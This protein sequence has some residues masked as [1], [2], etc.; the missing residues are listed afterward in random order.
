MDFDN[1][2]ES[3]KYL[4]RY[5]TVSD[6]NIFAFEHDRLYFSTPENFNDPFD[7]LIYANVDKILGDVA[8]H[9]R[10]GMDGYIEKLK[11]SNPQA[12]FLAYHFWNGPKK[13]EL[14]ESQFTAICE[15]VDYI[16]KTLRENVKIICFSEVYDSML[17]WSH[18]ANNHKGFLLMYDIEELKHAKRFT[19]DEIE[20]DKHIRVEKVKYVTE[21][22][23]LSE[24]VEDFVRCNMMPTMGD[25]DHGDGK[26]PQY[27]LKEFVI[28]KAKDWEYEQE[29]R[30]IPRIIDLE[31]PS[32]L[33]YIECT[34]KAVILGA[35][36]SQENGLK[37][38]KIAREKN[39]A[40]FGMYLNEFNPS[41]KLEIDEVIEKEI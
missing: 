35:D 10:V 37:L 23:D 25:V 40:T 9:L 14:V 1:V 18:Y 12:A 34:P 29:W 3:G 32:P 6:N 8:G 31:N 22:I 24:D 41:F 5:R 13:E 27:K 39:I 19:I 16:K 15:A 17:M 2:F 38:I 7:N 21:Q 36:C 20:V 26:I 30:M 33:G 11:N 4:F 28:Q